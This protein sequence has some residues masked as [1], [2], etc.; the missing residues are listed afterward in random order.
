MRS[1][2]IAIGIVVL[3]FAGLGIG[4]LL[5]RGKEAPQVNI[6]EEFPEVAG[7]KDQAVLE[8]P[9]VAEVKQ[10][11]D[12][13]QAEKIPEK[14]YI[15]VPFAPQAPF[16]NWDQPYQ[17]ACE[18][19]AIIM[20]H[21]YLQGKNLSRDAM[22]SE[23][24]KMVSWQNKNWGGHHDLEGTQIVSLAKK[25]YGYKN[26]K[27]KY[28]FSIEDVK[29]EIAAGNPVILPTAGRMLGNPNFR[30]AGPLYHALVVKGY[31]DDLIITN[32]PGTRKGLDYTYSASTIMNSS[33]EWNGGNVNSGRSAMIVI[34]N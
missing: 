6:K 18:E 24:L 1:K 4:F 26:I 27:I 29:K 8:L 33:H 9:K 21:Y 12:G 10:S 19:A 31:K 22:N 28:G 32:D 11:T 17:D 3:I 5:T 15:N 7:E 14:A 25:F 20:V 16:A 34:Y 30:G 13:S 2:Y 23:I